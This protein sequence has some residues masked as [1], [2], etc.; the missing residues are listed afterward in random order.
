[1]MFFYVSFKQ[2]KVPVPAFF[3]GHK[4]LMYSNRVA[5]TGSRVVD[6]PDKMSKYSSANLRESL[7]L[8]PSMILIIVVR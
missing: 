7:T 1:M 4:P 8:M 6:S 3:V 2:L 5:N